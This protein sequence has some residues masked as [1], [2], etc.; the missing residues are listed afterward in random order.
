MRLCFLFG[1]IDICL[2]LLKGD[3]HFSKRLEV[4]LDGSFSRGYLM[5]KPEE[6]RNA[7]YELYELISSRSIRDYIKT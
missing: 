7:I 6:C 1:W 3:E 4:G 2:V 5:R